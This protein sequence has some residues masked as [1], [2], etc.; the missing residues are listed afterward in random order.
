VTGDF[1]HDGKWDIALTGGDG[2]NT[3]PVAFSNNDGT[4]RVT[5][6]SAVSND[7]AAFAQGFCVP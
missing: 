5:N 4:F 1:D 7:F 6:K 2:W 3:V